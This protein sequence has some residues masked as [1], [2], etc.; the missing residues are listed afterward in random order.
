[1]AKSKVVK[2]A[3]VMDEVDVLLKEV[4]VE[5]A[6]EII[7]VKPFKWKNSLKAIPVIGDMIS[8]LT[9]NSDVIIKILQNAENANTN[10]E[11]V[12][13]LINLASSLNEVV[14]EDISKIIQLGTN[15]TNKAMDELTTE[16]GIDLSLAVYKVNK[17]FFM[18][19]FPQI[20]EEVKTEK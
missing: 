10:T 14:L 17:S 7:V 20:P 6:G 5:V 18:K 15:L 4:E 11:A 3:T 9:V 1:M 19:Y 16:E 8:Q 13:A 12:V 2:E